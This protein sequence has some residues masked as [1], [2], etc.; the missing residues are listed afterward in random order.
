MADELVSNEWT[1]VASD[2]RLGS[3]GGGSPNTKEE[4]TI[5]PQGTWVP[6]VDWKWLRSFKKH[7]PGC[8]QEGAIQMFHLAT[9][10]AEQV[11]LMPN[12]SPVTKGSREVQS[13]FG[14]KKKKE[15]KHGN[16]PYSSRTN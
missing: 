8:G 16:V 13:S 10:S 1:F 4:Y 11:K 5:T 9:P 3:W 12:R 7:C 15:R 14:L 2:S 6:A